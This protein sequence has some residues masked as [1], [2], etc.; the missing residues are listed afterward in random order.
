MRKSILP[1]DW[2]GVFGII[3]AVGVL[4]GQPA[5]VGLGTLVLL[6]WAVARTWNRLALERV[7]FSHNLSQRR[8]FPGEVV[9][10]HMQV[11]NSKSLP[12]PWLQV[13]SATPI[14][15]R[16]DT[17]DG[18]HSLDPS[19]GYFVSYTTS[20]SWYERVGWS[21]PILCERRGLYRF[22]PANISSG[23]I[24]G[25]FRSTMQAGDLAQ[26]LVYPHVV[27]LPELGLPAQKPFGESRG[28][29]RIFEDPSRVVGLRAYQQGDPM[30]RI[31]WKATARRDELQVRVYDPSVSNSMYVLLN[32]ATMAQDGPHGFQRVLLERAVTVAASV[33]SHAFQERFSLG[34]MTNAHSLLSEAATVIPPSRDPD[35]LNTVLEALAVMGSMSSAPLHEMIWAQFHSFP[36]GAT[37]VIVTA[38]M[39]DGLLDTLFELGRRG[40]QIFVLW[41]GDRLM[42]AS[43]QGGIQVYDVSREVGDLVPMMAGDEEIDGLE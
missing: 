18:G 19:R 35:Q 4:V 39:P 12:L 29:K 20:L 30:R 16:P 34:L 24:F 5:L 11:A 7:T 14:N 38:V 15:V 37:L 31:D 3:A 21:V 27:S 43:Q 33:A 25:F 41:V 23:D 9:Q 8:A 17:V 28:G 10:Y 40:Y 42:S 1:G 32:S 26:L 2:V 22:G 6:S 13:T 36:L